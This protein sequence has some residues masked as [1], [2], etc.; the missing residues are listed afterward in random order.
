MANEDR[1]DLER[2][3]K[4]LQHYLDRASI[5]MRLKNDREAIRDL[6]QVIHLRP[7]DSDIHHR[8]GWLWQ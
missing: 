4:S 3:L 7:D 1:E 6:D 5:W 8:R 2:A